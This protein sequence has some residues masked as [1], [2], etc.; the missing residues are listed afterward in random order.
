[1]CKKDQK[2]ANMELVQKGITDTFRCHGLQIN[3]KKLT[4]WGNG[5]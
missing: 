3:S 5:G 1:M 4:F 2:C